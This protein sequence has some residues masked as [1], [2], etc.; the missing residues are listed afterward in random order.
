MTTPIQ[1]RATRAGTVRSFSLDDASLVR[2]EFCYRFANEVLKTKSTG[3]TL[4]RRALSMLQAHFEALMIA[5]GD[6]EGLAR[7][8]IEA[9]QL[10]VANKGTYHIGVSVQQIQDAP[11]LKPILA[12]KSDVPQRATP[13]EMI[14]RDL[15]RWA[16]VKEHSL[17]ADEGGNDS[18]V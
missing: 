5:S 9:G 18:H 8:R 7:C 13:R 4:V 1:H 16:L 17:E 3:G 2:L 14:A 12:L 10:R 11:V 15:A 6:H